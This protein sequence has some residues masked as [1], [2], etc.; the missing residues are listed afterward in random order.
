MSDRHIIVGGGFYGC[1]VAE[2]VAARFPDSEVVLLEK[3]NALCLRATYNNQARIHNGYH[4]PRSI[5]TGL[6]SRINYPRF[7]REFKSCIV[8]DFTKVY[9]IESNRSNVTASQFFHF[10]D[11]IG[12]RI[13][14]APEEIRALFNPA[15][16]EGVYVVTECA[17][18]AE[19]LCDVMRERLDRRDVTVMTGTEARKVRSSKG[20]LRVETRGVVSG[21]VEALEGRYLYNCTYSNLNGLLSGSGLKTLDLKHEATE[22]ALVRVPEA[23]KH[24]GITVMCGPFFSVMPFPP[25]GRHSFSHVSYTPHYEW[26]E[27]P[28]GGGRAHTPRFP[29]RSNFDKMLRDAVRYVPALEG[30][31]YENSLWETKTVLPGSEQDDSRPILFVRAP[32][33]PN[34]I[35]I[36]GGKID[37]VFDIDRALEEVFAADDRGARGKS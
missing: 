14:P 30:C 12:A 9:A 10:C 24:L 31:V 15:L 25:Q 23:L 37:N 29:L 6:R 20:R 26:R 1:Y 13:E 27:R 11:R 16:I 5:L 33:M 21:R 32:Q 35:S 22:I 8:D 19:K 28:G 2:K 17:F 4:Y 3:E 18:D 7:R 36:L 34:V